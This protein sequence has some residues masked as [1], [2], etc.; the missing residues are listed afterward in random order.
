MT[1]S[2]NKYVS[3]PQQR[4]QCR[5]N[6][7][8]YIEKCGS[9]KTPV[10]M[11]NYPFGDPKH[12]KGVCKA[13]TC[14]DLRTIPADIIEADETEKE[15]PTCDELDKTT[16]ADSGPGNTEEGEV[17]KINKPNPEDIAKSA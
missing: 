9:C 3:F 12:K 14:T 13:S 11:C 4:E 8:T 1:K 7:Y 15:V 10:L 5:L 16:L 6:K 17:E 2:R